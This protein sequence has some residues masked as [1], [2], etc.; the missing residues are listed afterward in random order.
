MKELTTIIEELCLEIEEFHEHGVYLPISADNVEYF[1]VK[2]AKV[3]NLAFDLTHHYYNITREST[4]ILGSYKVKMAI[5][6]KELLNSKDV[7]NKPYS[8]V[9]AKIEAEVEYKDIE[10]SGKLLESEADAIKL[11]VTMASN[12]RQTLNQFVS[13]INKSF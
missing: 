9:K 7:N 11:Y 2:Q 4:Q 5:R 13:T 3:A 1:L 10:S 8:A 6:Q 12:I